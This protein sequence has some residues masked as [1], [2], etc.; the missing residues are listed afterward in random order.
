MTLTPIDRTG[1]VPAYALEQPAVME[2]TF[3][4]FTQLGSDPQGRIITWICDP[5][6][7]G[8]FF[9]TCKTAYMVW[10]ERFL[11]E[12]EGAERFV[13]QLGVPLFS[14]STFEVRV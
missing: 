13:E 10:Q 11:A 8:R 14:G 6:D 7:M 3:H 2:P 5:Q 4:P 9:V 12:E 1:A